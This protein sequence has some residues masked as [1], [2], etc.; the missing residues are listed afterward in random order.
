MLSTTTVILALGF[1]GAAAGCSPDFFPPSLF[2]EDAD[3]DSATAKTVREY[4]QAVGEESLL[5]S[6]SSTEVYRLTWLPNFDPGIM[7]KVTD[8]SNGRAKIVRYSGLAPEDGADV[9]TTGLTSKKW[10]LVRRQIEEAGFWD[11]MKNSPVPSGQLVVDGSIWVLEG[12]RGDEYKAVHRVFPRKDREDDAPFI[13][14]SI[15]ILRIIGV[16]VG[17]DNLY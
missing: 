15:G 13:E 6:G 9:H 17:E 4:L 5:D 7:V 14:L 16:D 12:V 11:T 1:S 2:Y 10:Q 8:S 3:W